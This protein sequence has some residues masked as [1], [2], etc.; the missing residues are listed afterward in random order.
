ME[1][2]ET[3]S[4]ANGTYTTAFLA[5]SSLAALGGPA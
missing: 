1:I 2:I 4:F 5:G 3:E